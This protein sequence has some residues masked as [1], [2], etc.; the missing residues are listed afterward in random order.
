MFLCEILNQAI[1]IQ[2][3]WKFEIFHPVEGTFTKQT[4]WHTHPYGACLVQLDLASFSPSKVFL[5]VPAI[6][7]RLGRYSA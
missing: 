5:A 7:K 1:I 2:I 4:T 6:V 3:A